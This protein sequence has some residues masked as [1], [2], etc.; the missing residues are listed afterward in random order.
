MRLTSESTGVVGPAGDAGLEDL[1]SRQLFRLGLSAGSVGVPGAAGAI[2]DVESVEGLH[3]VWGVARRSRWGVGFVARRGLTLQPD[4]ASE[5]RSAAGPLVAVLL[6]AGRCG[7]AFGRR[8]DELGLALFAWEPD[9]DPWPSNRH[10][11]VLV[12]AVAAAAVP[13]RGEASTAAQPDSAPVVRRVA[14]EAEVAEARALS[15]R[16]FDLAVS[17]FTAVA[18]RIISNAPHAGTPAVRAAHVELAT[19]EGVVRTVGRETL[20][21]EAFVEEVARIDEARQRLE[22]FV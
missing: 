10:A 19:V 5:V 8:A 12:E 13:A 7:E 16:Y 6:H 21:L 3:V 20:P 2:D 14:T 1:L 18:Q 9:A 17:A 11:E 15:Q 22:L 4:H